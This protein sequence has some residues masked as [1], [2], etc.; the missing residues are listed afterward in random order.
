MV[1]IDHAAP[2]QSYVYIL[3]KK[4]DLRQM[5]HLFLSPFTFETQICFIF[6]CFLIL[7]PCL[8][9][10]IFRF[11]RSRSVTVLGKTSPVLSQD[12]KRRIYH[13]R[14]YMNF[15]LISQFGHMFCVGDP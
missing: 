14:L 9:L 8:Y 7:V 13:S 11:R 12:V 10:A 5:Y 2:S 3:N 1:S 15:N 4:L 6:R